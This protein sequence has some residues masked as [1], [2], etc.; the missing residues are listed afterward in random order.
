MY[1]YT[2]ATRR[3]TD[4]AVLGEL[5]IYP[6]SPSNNKNNR[7]SSSRRAQNVFVQPQQQEEQLDIAVLG[8]LENVLVHPMQQQEQEQIE[9]SQQ[10]SEK[11]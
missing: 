1:S 6:Y 2:S 9:Q 7:Y 10:S 5:R 3:T 8:E 11:Y 4:L